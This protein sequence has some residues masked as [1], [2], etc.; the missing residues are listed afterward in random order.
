MHA[1]PVNFH[2]TRFLEI[3]RDLRLPERNGGN[4]KGCGVCWLKP[5]R[6]PCFGAWN[7][8]ATAWATSGAKKRKATSAIAE[9]ASCTL[10]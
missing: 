2:Q 10:P 1:Q 3:D 6:L 7:H 8:S 5:S 4:E 9:V